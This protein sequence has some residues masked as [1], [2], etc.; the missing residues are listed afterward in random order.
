MVKFV[1]YTTVAFLSISMLFNSCSNSKNP[2]DTKQA[3]E[4][5]NEQ[6]FD[7]HATEKNAQYLVDAYSN[8]LMEIELAKSVK[9]KTA[10]QDVKKMADM[11]ISEHTQV[12]AQL[13]GF[14]DQKNIA[15]PQGLSTDQMDETNKA[16]KKEG[17]ELD[18]FYVDNLVS[19]HKDA[20]KLYET[21]ADKEQDA[22]LKKFFASALP[23]LKSH[24]QMAE[25]LNKK[26]D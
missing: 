15:L 16:M 11:M 4:G 12:N 21:A 13:K 9:D 1:N 5:I 19:E 18:K 17:H 22:D 20:V 26:I 24:L 2:E 6:N 14:A 10:N 3:A 23:D 25:D 8:G 7:T